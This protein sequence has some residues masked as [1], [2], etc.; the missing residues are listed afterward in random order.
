M[1]KRSVEFADLLDHLA[2]RENAAAARVLESD[3]G[4]AARARRLLDAGRRAETAPVP[5]KRLL[6]RARRIWIR[7][8]KETR[9]SVLELLLDTMRAPAPAIALRRG[10]VASAR[11]RFLKFGGACT[12]ELQVTVRERGVELRGQVTPADAAPEAVVRAG[13]RVRRAP[14]AGDGTFVFPRLPRG[15]IELGLGSAVIRDV[16]I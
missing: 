12:V 4:L 15:R 2:G 6:A 9:P 10:R 8:R 11:P 7:E 5:G 1:G 16:E 3:P 14:V 13:A